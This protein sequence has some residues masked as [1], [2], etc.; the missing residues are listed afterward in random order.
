MPETIFGASSVETV[1]LIIA[2]I[3]VCRAVKRVT[4]Q[5]TDVAMDMA[6]W[7]AG[8]FLLAIIISA[9]LWSMQ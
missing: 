3:V 7:I 6:P 9:G 2:L 1:L 8:L 5:A 4:G